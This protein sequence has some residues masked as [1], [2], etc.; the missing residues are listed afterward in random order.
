MTPNLVTPES[1][2]PIARIVFERVCAALPAELAARLKSGRNVRR[3]GTRNS[4][5]LSGFWDRHQKSGVIDHRYL[6]YE[7]VYD[8]DHTYSGGTDWYMGL[9]LNPNRLYQH[10]TEVLAR[11][12]P[13]L[14][15]VQIPGFEWH[16]PANWIGIIHRFDFPHPLGELPDCLVPRYVSLV[17]AVHPIL[18]PVIDAFTQALTPADRAE[19][20]AGRRPARAVNAVITADSAELSRTIPS[21]LRRRVLAAYGHR[22]A[23]CGTTAARAG[24][25]LEIDHALPVCHGGLT[26]FDNLQPLCP[27][28]HQCKGTRSHRYPPLDPSATT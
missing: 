28:C 2:T 25:A 9:Y 24:A 14:R 12:E 16:R 1:L 7:H 13:A 17:R 8:P 4:V 3:H 23:A 5:L 6:C 18:M 11:L 20:I 19:V 22:C 10:P 26:R 21:G 15:A 27:P